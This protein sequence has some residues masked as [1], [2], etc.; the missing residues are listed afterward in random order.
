[1]HYEINVAKNGKHYFATAKRSI[2]TFMDAEALY[3]EFKQLFPVAD[4]YAIT[5]RKWQ[6]S[7]LAISQTVDVELFDN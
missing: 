6:K 2:R 1:M 5:V 4:G 3:N 7:D